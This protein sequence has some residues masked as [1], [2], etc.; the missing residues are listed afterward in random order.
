MASSLFYLIF[1]K[2]F[3][4]IYIESRKK[5]LFMILFENEKNVLIGVVEDLIEHDF[6]W[7]FTY[8]TDRY[9][10]V[11][12]HLHNW[13]DEHREYLYN[14]HLTVMN[15]VTRVVVIPESEN[16][17]LKFN[18]NDNDKQDY[19]DREA[20]NFQ[21]A[22]EEGLS[23]YFAAMYFLG[24]IGGLEVYAQERVEVDE[25]L[26]SDSFYNYTYNTYYSHECC[27][28]EEDE[29]RIR[30]NVWDDSD[31]L[32]NEDRIYAMIENSDAVRLV[33]FCNYYDINDLHSGNWGYRN[34]Q[35]V[36]IDYAG[37]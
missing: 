26:T 7:A 19:N 2:I 6:L 27:E 12:Y 37:Y 25:D 24:I 16:W 10:C 30:D 9:G 8:T 22:C 1:L 15:G 23:D 21:Y 29:E 32:G 18:F 3:A 20:R 35:A 31:T 4:I 36:L 11:K 5:V 28:N 33:R 17:V 13:I 34:G 14:N